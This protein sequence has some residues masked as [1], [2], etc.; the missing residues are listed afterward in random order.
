M[1]TTNGSTPDVQ[2]NSPVD[3]SNLLDEP[4]VLDYDPAEAAEMFAEMDARQHLDLSQCVT[5]AELVD[6]QA[7]FYRGWGNPVGTMLA[8][9]MKE[10]ALRIRWIK[11]ETPADYEARHE[12]VEQ[13][14][15]DTWFRQGF[16]EG[17][18]QGRSEA[19]A[20]ADGQLD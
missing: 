20:L 4:P 14:A 6:H 19:G 13:D 9:H 8:K 18:Q 7:D 1:A 11:A 16:E 12:I 10:L 2:I 3:L 17:R 15:R 5:L